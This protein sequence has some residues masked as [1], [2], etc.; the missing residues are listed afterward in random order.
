M[1]FI[2]RHLIGLV[3]KVGYYGGEREERERER[4]RE[5]IIDKGR[6][7]VTGCHSNR[8]EVTY[9]YSQKI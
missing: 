8:R 4:E 2:K 7:W 3:W 9:V 1:K 6:A 5:P